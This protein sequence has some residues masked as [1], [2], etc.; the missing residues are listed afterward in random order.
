MI[1]NQSQN[2]D[3]NNN[4]NNINNNE[5]PGFNFFGN[6]QITSGENIVK[7]EKNN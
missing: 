1:R 2:L 4:N 5:E 6:N 7:E 3:N